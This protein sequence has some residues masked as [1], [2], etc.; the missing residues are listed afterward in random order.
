MVIKKAVDVDCEMIEKYDGDYEFPK[1]ANAI[2]P[3]IALYKQIKIQVEF[4]EKYQS[5]I[6]RVKEETQPNN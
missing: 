6:N 4:I 1:Q 5:V 2:S 3:Y